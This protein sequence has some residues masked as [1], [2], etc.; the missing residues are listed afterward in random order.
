[1][2]TKLKQATEDLHREIEKDNLATLII[3]NKISVEEYKL[4]LLQN[5]ISYAVT[6]S[7]IAKYLANYEI[8][9]T[10]RLLR[11]LEYLGVKYSITLRVRETLRIVNQAED[12]GAAYVVEGSAVDGM[13]IAKEIKNCQA[14]D[15][16][17]DHHFFNGNRKNVKSWN[18]F[19]KFLKEQEF[20]SLEEIHA[21]DK[22]KETFLFF[23][24]V[25]KTTKLPD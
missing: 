20:T 14:L 25:F 17:K 7:S 19:S 16:I 4:L 6:E 8:H 21:I 24:E 9:K 12:L 11:D 23:G 5:Y 15:V 18:T 13:V 22:A 1:M 2:L 10:P 3:S